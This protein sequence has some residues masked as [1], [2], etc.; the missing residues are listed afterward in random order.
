MAELMQKC[1][2]CGREIELFR[3]SCPIC[4]YVIRYY[5][6]TDED[7]QAKLAEIQ[8]GWTP[9][10]ESQRRSVDYRE[11]YEIPRCRHNPKGRR[12][13]RERRDD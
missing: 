7:M 1:I 5:V 3:E 6:P 4:R 11:T 8:A 12:V 10:Q 9:G 13:M 2:A